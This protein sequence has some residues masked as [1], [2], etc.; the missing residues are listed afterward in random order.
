M[1]KS[2]KPA[3]WIYPQPALVIVSQDKAGETD[4]MVAAWGGHLWTT[5]KDWL[6]ARP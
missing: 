4:A 6:H 2:F 3:S 1:K 5:N